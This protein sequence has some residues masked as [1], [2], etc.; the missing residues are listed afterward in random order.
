MEALK[1]PLKDCDLLILIILLIKE[2][3]YSNEKTES[4]YMYDAKH[5]EAHGGAHMWNLRKVWP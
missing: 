5:R 2:K 1:L 4:S 3:W